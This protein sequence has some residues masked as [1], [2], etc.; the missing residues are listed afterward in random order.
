[1]AMT[2]FSQQQ[3]QKDINAINYTFILCEQSEKGKEKA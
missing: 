2:L 3:Q 1:M